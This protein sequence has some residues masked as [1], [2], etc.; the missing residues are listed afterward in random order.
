M[1]KL[2]QRN[3]LPGSLIVRETFPDTGYCRTE[4][5]VTVKAGMDV[6][7]VLKIVTGKYVWCAAADVALAVAILVDDNIDT[8]TA[9]DQTLVVF[10][11]GPCQVS[12]GAITFDG[13]VTEGN[14][15][16]AV[17]ALRV[18]NIEVIAGITRYSDQ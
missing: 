18:K 14:I 13:A 10:D 7:A 12:R 4:G 11:D 2:L 9:G 5:I 17:A 8:A 1:T 6:G 15:D 3:N 16:T